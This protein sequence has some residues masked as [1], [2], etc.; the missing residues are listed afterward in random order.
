MVGDSIKMQVKARCSSASNFLVTSHFTQSKSGSSYN[1]PPGRP[2]WWAPQTSITWSTTTLWPSHWSWYRPSTL[3]PKAFTGPSAGTL[4]PQV[5]LHGQL[6]PSHHLLS[7]PYQDH[8]IWNRQ[9]PCV[10]S[11]ASL[12]SLTSLYLIF[13]QT[14]WL[15]KVLC[16]FVQCSP[17]NRI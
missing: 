13:L 1:G 8:I 6:P 4:F 15:S 16:S 14:H 7:E 11:P 12:M 2:T 5:S 17:P 3:L 9:R 10:P